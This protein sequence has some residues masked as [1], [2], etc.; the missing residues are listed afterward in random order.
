MGSTYTR[1]SRR[2]RRGEGGFTLIELLVVIAVLTILAAIVLFNITGLKNKGQSAAC[3]TDTKTVQTAVDSYI[4]DNGGLGSLTTGN[5][6][7]GD[8]ATLHTAGYLHQ[9][10]V[11]CGTMT[12]TANGS[13]GYDVAGS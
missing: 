5:M 3:S 13:N 10:T 2:H 12:L 9:S 7:T 11:S 1:F 4:N 6:L 8:I